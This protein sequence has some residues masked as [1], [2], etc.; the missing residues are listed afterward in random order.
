[1]TKL[2]NMSMDRGLT[3]LETLAANGGLSLA[4]LHKITDIPK[5]PLR[6]LLSTMMDRDFVRRSV[7]DNRY[8]TNILIP[9]LT[10]S[11]FLP[12][13]SDL[14]DIIMPHAIA[15]TAEIGWPTDIH[16]LGAG[17]MT[18][19][20]STRK[21]SPFQLYHGQI[22]LPLNM[23]GSASGVACLSRCSLGYVEEMLDMWEGDA[24]YG[25]DRFG[26]T[27][28]AYFDVLSQAK[29]LGYGI[30]LPNYQGETELGVGL[31]A[32][33]VPFAKQNR[34]I[35]AAVTMYPRDYR[36]T[37]DFAADFFDKLN[38]TANAITAALS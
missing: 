17:C 18:M 23:F 29:E 6:R 37:E 22:N 31:A 3:V 20:D 33:A 9:R 19:V 26:I 14:S 12:H 4:Q 25:L 11:G 13:L 36:S 35:G 5:T 28:T 2:Q 21:L 1:M 32:I 8:R 15:L 16:L 7:A 24:F 27:R 38:S 10:K 34:P 30:R